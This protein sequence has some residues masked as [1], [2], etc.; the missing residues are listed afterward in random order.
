M[1][2][3]SQSV[4]CEL[5]L[6]SASPRRAEILEVCGVS[7][8]IV[9]AAIDESAVPGEEPSV[10]VRRMALAKAEAVSSRCGRS[11]P[12]LAADTAVVIDDLILGKPSGIEDARRMLKRLSGRWHEVYS[13][14]AIIHRKAEVISVCT[15]VRFRS[16]TN[17]EI[18]AYWRSGEPRD[19]AGSY[20]IQGIGGA[21]VE[22]I[23]GSYSNVVGLPLGETLSL[24][25]K[26]GI[27]H[28]LASNARATGKSP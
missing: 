6:A 3:K 2:A 15:G 11:T 16:I 12:V 13:G 8:R 18:N 22:R 21:F 24:L 4:D 5:L 1:S 19:K 14:V 26:Y 9:P 23:S 28:I 10:Y 20:A 17:E 7:H 25:G 27:G